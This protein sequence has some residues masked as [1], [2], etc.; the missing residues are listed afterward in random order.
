MNWE[1]VLY[2]KSDR[3]A[4]ITMNRPEVLNAQDT[5]L[6][7]EVLEAFEHANEDDEVRVIILAGAGRSFSSGHD[8]GSQRARA[9][10]E[11]HPRRPGAEGIMEYEEKYF[12]DWCLRVHD[13]PKPTIAQV[14]G[15]AIIGG[16]MLAN[17]CDLIVAADNAIFS[18]RAAR[19]AAP[20]GEFHTYVYDLGPRK[21]KE[22]L[23]T[24]NY[25]PATELYR[26][27]MIN[28][29]APPDQLEEETMQ[30]AREVA[31]TDSF[32]LKLVKRSVNDVLDAMGFRNAVRTQHYL[33]MMAHAHYRIPEVPPVV[34]REEGQSV[35]E[36]AKARDAAYESQAA[37]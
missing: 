5:Q 14:Q 36:W 6:L 25:I 9:Y 13:L 22:L 11:T 3:I 24:G 27:G 10:Q 31:A 29:L 16:W 4:K 1:S 18:D 7:T 37:N 26:L 8:L 20:S 35:R 21:A 19:W 32:L 28:R 30:L 2:E 15:Y 17:A 23:F 12:V 33:H 34:P